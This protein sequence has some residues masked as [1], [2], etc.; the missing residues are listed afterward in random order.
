MI[1]PEPEPSLSVTSVGAS[2]GYLSG[3]PTNQDLAPWSDDKFRV[4]DNTGVRNF[5]RDFQ[6]PYRGREFGGTMLLAR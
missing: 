3:Y 2:G 6:G 1:L 4:A 5:S